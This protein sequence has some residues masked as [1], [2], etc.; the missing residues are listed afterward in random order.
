M[1]GAGF[2]PSPRAGG[3]GCCAW[4]SAMV[5][6]SLGGMNG[7]NM[8]MSLLGGCHGGHMCGAGAGD[9]RVLWYCDTA[10]VP[11]AWESAALCSSFASVSYQ[12]PGQ[13]LASPLISPPA[14]RL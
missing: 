7:Q 10:A 2:A 6:A 14:L 1:V 13:L 3:R 5:L 8:S 11:W 12:A 4:G 9:S